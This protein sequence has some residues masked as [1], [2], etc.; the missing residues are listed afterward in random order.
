MYEYFIEYS[1]E[2]LGERVARTY[3]SAKLEQA[4]KLDYTACTV[5]PQSEYR[6]VELQTKKF[7]PFTWQLN[8]EHCSPVYASVTYVA[9]ECFNSSVVVLA[10]RRHGGVALGVVLNLVQLGVHA[11]ADA[12]I[13]LANHPRTQNTVLRG[14]TVQ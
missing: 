8:A 9:S 5:L 3:T 12:W 14:A 4:G 6:Y 13:V 1:S 11:T 2:S 7:R 10:Q